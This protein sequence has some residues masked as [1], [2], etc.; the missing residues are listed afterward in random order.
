MDWRGGGGRVHLLAPQARAGIPRLQDGRSARGGR[1]RA[2]MPHVC[3]CGRKDPQWKLGRSGSGSGKIR[4]IYAHT[5]CAHTHKISGSTSISELLRIYTV[6]EIRS[7]TTTYFTLL[8]FY[9]SYFIRFPQR[10]N[11]RAGGGSKARAYLLSR[12]S[13]TR[14]R[15]RARKVAMCSYN[16]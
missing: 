6:Y 10:D 3:T 8:L 13:A 16:P 11:Q 12:F 9:T 2:R 14:T 15:W 1:A 7:Y 4:L 5:R